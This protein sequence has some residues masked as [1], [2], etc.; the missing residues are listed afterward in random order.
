MSRARGP[1]LITG[2]SSVIQKMMRLIIAFYAVKL[3]E[4][5]FGLFCGFYTGYKY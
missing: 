1:A 2:P 3:G 5:F 4:L